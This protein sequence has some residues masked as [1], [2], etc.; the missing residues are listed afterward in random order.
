MVHHFLNKGRPLSDLMNLSGSDKIFH[1]ASC[2]LDK[3]E[4]IELVKAV[5]KAI[6]GNNKKR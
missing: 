4:K 1:I 5:V 6:S 3:E 2:R